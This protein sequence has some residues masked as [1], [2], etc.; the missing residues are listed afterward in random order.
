MDTIKVAD[1]CLF[2]MSRDN[3]ID[4]FGQSLFELI[5]AFHYP[6]SVFVVTGIKDLPN[7]SQS[8]AKDKLQKILDSKY[9]RSSLDIR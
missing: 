9:L 8:L 5:Y 7:K 1:T 4:E 3:G 6:S 2:I